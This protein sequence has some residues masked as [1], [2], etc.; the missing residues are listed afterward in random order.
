MKVVKVK[1]H[2]G[3][4][5]IINLEHIDYI[6]PDYNDVCFPYRY[7]KLDDE[8]IKKVVDLIEI[9]GETNEQTK[10]G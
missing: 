7:V 4:E 3:A 1:T 8:S 9:E 5:I 2:A 6:S 10:R